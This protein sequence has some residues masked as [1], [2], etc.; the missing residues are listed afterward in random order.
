MK[1]EWL[2]SV[3]FTMDDVKLALLDYLEKKAH[4]LPMPEDRYVRLGKV[5]DRAKADDYLDI[6]IDDNKVH[7]MINGAVFEEEL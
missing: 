4:E 3:V 5:V 6:D 2:C 1:A 7:L